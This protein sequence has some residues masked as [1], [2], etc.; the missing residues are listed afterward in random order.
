VKVG[1]NGSR[2][3]KLFSLMDLDGPPID[4]ICLTE[5]FSVYAVAVSNPEGLRPALRVVLECKEP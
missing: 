3:R 1:W 4:F 2:L 5:G